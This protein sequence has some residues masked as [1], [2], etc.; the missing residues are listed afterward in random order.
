MQKL[1]SAEQTRMAD[2]FAIEQEPIASIDLMER[3]SQAF[4]REFLKHFSKTNSVQ[5]IAGTGNNGGD[6]LAIGRMLREVGFQV[7]VVLI[8]VS[9]AITADC[10][11][12]LNRLGEEVLIQTPEQFKSKSVDVIIDALFGSGLNRPVKGTL[13]NIISTIN[14]SK[15][16]VVAV[17]IPSG[18]F[19]DDVNLEGAI[20]R[21][22]L[23]ITF[24][25]PK[26]SFLLPETG[27]FIG[28]WIAVDIGLNEAFI[29]GLDSS[30]YLINN[31]VLDLLPLRI[32]FQHKGHF[33]RV[34]VF[35][36][37]KGKIGAAFL[38]GKAVMRAGAG[39]LTIHTP[40]C[41]MV[42]LQAS[43]PEAMLTVDE[44]QDYISGGSLFEDTDVLCFGS[45]VGIEQETVECFKKLLFSRPKHL[46]VD[47][48]GLNILAMNPKL[49]DSLPEG[50]VLTPHV[51]EFHRLFGHHK[52]G[53]ARIQTAKKVASS[54]KLVIVIKGAHSAV[55]DSIGGVY[56][57]STGN[58]GMATAGSGDV[59][60]GI[61]TGLLAQGLT[62]QNAAKLG[63]YIHGKSG[64]L[65]AKKIGQASL[66]ASDLLKFL[67]KALSN[68]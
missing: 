47:A 9:E 52:D 35:A 6:G 60:A 66:M 57:N 37:S 58:P 36:G 21:A 26:L 48:D 68:E 20:V 5:I 65:V 3:A 44:A 12:N 19:A 14:T 18:L 17:D 49:I 53:L 11:L 8:K 61:I 56:F 59:L 45:G 24:Q 7:E 41:G 2:Q 27:S 31:D 1:I 55:I 40:S 4:F 63:V 32:K 46:V 30:Y 28:D 15:A 25:R 33:G 39:L 43:L 34:Q 64:D 54:R 22:D 51:G 16:K 67:P 38:C 42:I 10:Q 29:E 13:E 23:T 50:T 62:P